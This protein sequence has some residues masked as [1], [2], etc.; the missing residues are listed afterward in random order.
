MRGGLLLQQRCVLDQ[1]KRRSG[2]YWQRRLRFRDLRNALL[3][4]GMQHH[5]HVWL[6]FMLHIRSVLIPRCDDQLRQC[7]FMY[8]EHVHARGKLR[9]RRKL[10]RRSRRAVPQWLPLRLFH[11]L[12]HQL[13]RRLPMR[14][15]VLLQRRLMCPESRGRPGVHLRGAVPLRPMP[16]RVL[17][18]F[19][20]YH[21]RHLR[22]DGVCV[23]NGTLQLS[24][25]P[26]QRPELRRGRADE[27]RVVLERNLPN[28]DHHVLWQLRLQR[29]Q[30]LL[31]L[32][33]DGRRVCQRLLLQRQRLCRQRIRRTG[34]HREQRLHLRYLHDELL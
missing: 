7:R 10:Q 6:D 16:R 19:D 21:R 13:Y 27:R 12:L 3:Q 24:E 26:M 18:C 31:H 33:H 1:G 23:W 28:G 25:Q 29:N 34:L 15:G 5:G 20:L 11:R 17:L 4:W 8:R 14:H 2:L 22:S 32:V 30:R 9:R